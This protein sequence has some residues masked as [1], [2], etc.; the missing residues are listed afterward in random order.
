MSQQQQQQNNPVTP[1]TPLPQKRSF[2]QLVNLNALIMNN[3]LD[4]EIDSEFAS[5]S[6]TVSDML[7][8]DNRLAVQVCASLEYKEMKGRHYSTDYSE[9]DTLYL[10]VW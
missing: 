3:E 10:S 4:S 9:T 6:E 1:P 7:L 8:I 2:F 5:S